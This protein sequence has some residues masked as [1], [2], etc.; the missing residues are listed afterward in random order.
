MFYRYSFWIRSICSSVWAHRT[1]GF[2]EIQAP[3]LLSHTASSSGVWSRWEVTPQVYHKDLWKFWFRLHKMPRYRARL[4]WP[5]CNCSTLQ[6]TK[7][8][9]CLLSVLSTLCMAEV[10]P[11]DSNSGIFILPN[12][13]DL[14]FYQPWFWDCRHQFCKSGIMTAVSCLKLSNCTG[15]FSTQGVF[16]RLGT[17]S[18]R[19][20]HHAWNHFLWISLKRWCL[21]LLRSHPLQR[22]CFDTA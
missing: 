11:S 18:W 9:G 2:S 22:K 21:S 12:S 4:G 13:C 17:H 7:L 16:L 14:G 1:L 5:C 3:Q 8:L 20:R 19:L 10:R 6:W 15:N